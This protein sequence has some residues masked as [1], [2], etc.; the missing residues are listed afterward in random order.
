[1]RQIKYYKIADFVFSL[2]L[3][4]GV[5][6]TTMLPSFRTFGT[7]R[8]ED[9]LFTFQVNAE[10]LE[11]PSGFELIEKTESDVGKVSMCRTAAGNWWLE[12]SY[13]DIDHYMSVAEDFS[14][15]S[16]DIDLDDPDS[17]MVLCSMLRIMWS[18]AV[19]ALGGISVHA[20][21]VVLGGV[22]YLFLGKSGTGKSTHSEL[23]LR[24][25]REA[26]LL[27]DDNPAIRVIDGKAFAYGT[28]WSGKKPVYIDKKVP[29]G[30]IVRLEQSQVNRMTL[31][32][33]LD[34]FLC[35]YPSC[36]ALHRDPVQENRLCDTLEILSE[37]VP[38]GLMECRPDDKAAI[39]CHETILKDNPVVSG[40]SETADTQT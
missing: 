19:L 5:D 40:T 13:T 20:S 30:G 25:F 17:G 27:N 28:P 22:A 37:S 6:T 33:G 39:I 38:V 11:R 2:D 12:M 36:S 31:K 32:E 8:A 29:L 9:L 4:D 1:M 14:S 34:A 7:C 16:S 18:Q 3:P 35:I 10:V 21:A 26:W 24:N 23:W 15:A